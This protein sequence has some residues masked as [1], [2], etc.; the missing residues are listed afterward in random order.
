[1]HI[2]FRLQRGRVSNTHSTKIDGKQKVEISMHVDLWSNVYYSKC[3]TLD[4]RGRELDLWQ[5]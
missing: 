5:I 4:W 1:M 2:L 3:Q